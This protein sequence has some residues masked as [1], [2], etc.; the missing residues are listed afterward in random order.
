MSDY[1]ALRLP[2][3]ERLPIVT[4]TNLFWPVA[5]TVWMS[6]QVE[7]LTGY[8]V[9]QWVGRPGFFESILHPDDRAAVLEE[10]RVSRMEL[11]PLSQDYRLVG[12]D[13]RVI[14]IHDES[15]P[16]LDDAGR[17]ELVQ[18]YFVDVTPRVKLE[19]QLLHAQKTEALGRLAGEIAHDFNNHLTAIRGYAGFLDE[20]LPAGSDEKRYAHEI[21]QATDWATQ[22]TR[23]LLA[24]GRREP[25]EPRNVAVDALVLELAPMLARVAGDLVEIDL[26]LR[27]TPVV[28]A[29]AGQLEQVVVNLVANA[30]DAMPGGGRLRIGTSTDGAQA[31]VSVTDDGVG[32][33]EETQSHVFEPFYTTKERDRG[34]GLGLSIVDSVV[35]QAG[36]TVELE[37][38][39]GEGTRIC[40]SLPAAA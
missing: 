34:S 26:D 23:R 36:G 25:I 19:E 39:P 17:P 10:A 27:P 33:D 22:L 16:I 15:V 4:Y 2:L 11:R 9:E 8:S 14:W 13:G 18:G 3:S 12:G 37:S 5:E 32:M 1:A 21:V 20:L 40:I 28:Y 29:D 31:V 35:R 24:F 38:A 7:R 6:P 30:R